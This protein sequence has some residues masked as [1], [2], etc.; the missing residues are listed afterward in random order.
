MVNRV[1]RRCGVVVS[2]VGGS[3]FRAQSSRPCSCALCNDTRL[4]IIRDTYITPK[5][6]SNTLQSVTFLDVILKLSCSINSY[7]F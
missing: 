1:W 7:S 5:F 2:V 4:Y 3:L 6:K